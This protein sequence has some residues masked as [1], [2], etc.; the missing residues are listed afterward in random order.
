MLT[1]P[2]TTKAIRFLAMAHASTLA[3]PSDAIAALGADGRFQVDYM[4]EQQRLIR[5]SAVLLQRQGQDRVGLMSRSRR[6]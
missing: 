4:A 1:R 5:E 6:S 3:A 2:L